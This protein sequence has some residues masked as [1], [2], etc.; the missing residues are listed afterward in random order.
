MIA[1]FIKSICLNF[2][3]GIVVDVADVG[4]M[5]ETR[6]MGTTG[7]TPIVTKAGTTGT[8][9]TGVIV[10]AAAGTN[11]GA[12][13]TACTTLVGGKITTVTTHTTMATVVSMDKAK[14]S[15][16]AMG[17]SRDSMRVNAGDGGTGPVWYKYH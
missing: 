8:T 13:V 10:V 14:A 12:T 2:I 1:H 6:E 16:R 11:T 3:E 15:S 7:V 4:V 9:G 17:S 5:D